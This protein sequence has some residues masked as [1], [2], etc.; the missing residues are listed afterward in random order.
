ME[1]SPVLRGWRGLSG[2]SIEADLSSREQVWW[3]TMLSTIKRVDDIYPIIYPIDIRD[4]S[5]NWQD[6]ILPQANQTQSHHQ[7]SFKKSKRTHSSQLRVLIVKP[8]K[9]GG[10]S[11]MEYRRLWVL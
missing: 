7:N 2:Q 9:G 4:T 3:H 5:I 10:T 11:V 1:L 6:T 8:V